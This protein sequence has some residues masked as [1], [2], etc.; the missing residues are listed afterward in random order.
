[1]DFKATGTGNMLLTLHLRDPAIIGR[2][3]WKS[4]VPGLPRQCYTALNLPSAKEH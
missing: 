3:G 2:A 4:Q 1:M